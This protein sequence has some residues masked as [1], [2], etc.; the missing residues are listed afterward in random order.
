MGK[1]SVIQTL[2]TSMVGKTVTL[3]FG[4]GLENREQIGHAKNMTN[5]RVKDVEKLGE[6]VSV[7][8][9]DGKLWYSVQLIEEGRLVEVNGDD[10]LVGKRRKK[11]G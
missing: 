10:F 2:Q 4:I 7:Y 9:V 6:I 1:S 5:S 8:L 3:T 11:V